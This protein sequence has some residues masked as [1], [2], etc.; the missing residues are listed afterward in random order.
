MPH[1]AQNLR[2]RIVGIELFEIKD[3][4][5]KTL[6]VGGDERLEGISDVNV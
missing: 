3:S 1:R 6:L 2:I 5:M 4:A